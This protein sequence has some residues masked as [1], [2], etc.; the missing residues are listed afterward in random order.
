MTAA[1]VGEL[2]YPHAERGGA[3]YGR[4]MLRALERH[5]LARDAQPDSEHHE[6]KRQI[7]ATVLGC[8]FSTF[9]VDLVKLD[10]TSQRAEWRRVT[11]EGASALERLMSVQEVMPPSGFYDDCYLAA[12]EIPYGRG[13]SGVL[14]KLNRVFG[15]IVASLPPRL[16][17]WEVTPQEWRKELGLAGNASKETCA[18]AVERIGRIYLSHGG[19]WPQDALDAYAVA[20]Y[21]R[22]VNARGNE[23]A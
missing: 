19:R 18:E 20:Y 16:H 22:Q 5:G 1:E 9:A 21:A 11:L 4:S 14:A 7:M 3:Y 2:L 15:A 12:I 8:D 10:E 13:Q 6:G 17:L 23:A